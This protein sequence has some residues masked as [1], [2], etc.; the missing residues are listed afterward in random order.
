M[1][2]RRKR[3]VFIK[4]NLITVKRNTL[5]KQTEHF[6]ADKIHIKKNYQKILS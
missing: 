5:V 2:T 6:N 1:T 3:V 4:P